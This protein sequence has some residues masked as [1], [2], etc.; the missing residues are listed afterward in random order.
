M[1]AT[2]GDRRRLLEN[3]GRATKQLAWSPDGRSIAVT[4]GDGDFE[5]FVV[6]VAGSDGR[7]VTDNTEATRAVDLVARRRH[8]AYVSA[9]ED[10]SVP[11]S[12][13]DGAR[14]AGLGCRRDPALVSG[15]RD[16]LSRWRR[17]EAAHLA[18]RCLLNARY[19]PPMMQPVTDT[20]EQRG[21]KR[22]RLRL[23]LMA[24]LVGVSLVAAAVAAVAAIRASER[25]GAA[26]NV[27]ASR[28]LA[29]AAMRTLNDE[30]DLAMLLALEAFQRVRDRPAAETYEARNSLVS[31][32][33]RYP[34][35]V[36]VLHVDRGAAAVEFSSDGRWLATSDADGTTRLW[37]A[38]RRAPLG[39][40]MRGAGSCFTVPVDID[41]RFA[42]G[43]KALVQTGCGV[44]TVL[45][46]SSGRVVRRLGGPTDKLGEEE[47]DGLLSARRSLSGLRGRVEWNASAR[48]RDRQDDLGAI[49]PL[50]QLPISAGDQTSGF[51]EEERQLRPYGRRSGAPRRAHGLSGDFPEAGGEISG[52]A[53]G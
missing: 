28:A 38:Q 32:L 22:R 15:G 37:G 14:R 33:M 30:P 5:I 45:D 35:L 44:A 49:R 21:L 11:S 29:A 53:P 39:T 24:A 12:A 48:R 31:A 50:G 27:A 6:D 26:D 8:I 19:V 41:V 25:A 9:D 46:P 23:A 18:E 2:G 16:G 3:G 40:A 51:R 52:P 36:S 7:N 34:H 47:T 17:C 43:D 1:N 10:G 4:H 42:P 20:E 13:G